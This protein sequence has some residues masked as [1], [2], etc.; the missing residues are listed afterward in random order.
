MRITVI[1]HDGDAP[2]GF[3]AEWLGLACETVRPYLGEPVPEHAADG[4]IV[5][6]G[7]MA[8]WEDDRHP[9]LPP[10]R[11]LIARSVA[12]GVPTLGICLGAQLMT[13]A[14]GGRVERGGRGLEVGAC[15]V[16]A[17]PAAAEDRLFA[18]VGT[19]TAVQYHRDAMTALPEG[20]VPLLTG[21]RYPNQAYRLGERAWGVQFHP[22]ATP[23]IFGR[24]AAMTDLAP[25]IAAEVTGA[26]ADLVATWRP[27]ARAF[28]A[29][30]RAS[31]APH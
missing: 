31:A 11:A 23:E 16:M 27:V 1:E 13:L 24:W 29:V 4:L 21:E 20:A 26:E 28:A 12:A 22:E 15:A 30:V 10:T 18:T 14:C 3:L 17:L 25:E 19:A 2:L 6:G 7:E 5:L 8:A 9:W